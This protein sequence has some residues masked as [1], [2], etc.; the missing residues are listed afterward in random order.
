MRLPEQPPQS[1]NLPRGKRRGRRR[2]GR[3]RRAYRGVEKERRGYTG[4]TKDHRSGRKKQ[5]PTSRLTSM[6][7]LLCL[8]L[9]DGEL[10]H[11]AVWEEEDDPATGAGGSH[12]TPRTFHSSRSRPL[13]TA[14]TASRRR[15]WRSHCAAGPTTRTSRVVGAQ[16]CRRRVLRATASSSAAMRH[17]GN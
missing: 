8:D 4:D 6:P 15:R 16:R 13:P 2:K 14:L 12:Q 10:R 7:L 11:A 9:Q 3:R 17:P 5:T 1:D